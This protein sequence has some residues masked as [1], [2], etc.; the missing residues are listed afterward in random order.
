MWE[1]AACWQLVTAVWSNAAA[2][3]SSFVADDCCATKLQHSFNTAW[4]GV[5]AVQAAVCRGS[6]VV[7][8][9]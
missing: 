2:T 5:C 8:T 4:F 6:R 9:K 7:Y 3:A 1:Q